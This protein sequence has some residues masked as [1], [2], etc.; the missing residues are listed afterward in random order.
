MKRLAALIGACAATLVAQPAPKLQ[1]AK[2]ET[3]AVSGSLDATVRAIVAAHD[4]PAWIGYTEPAVPGDRQMCCFNSI[5]GV[6]SFG[7]SLEPSQGNIV[8]PAD[9]NGV[10]R[11]EGPSEFYLFLRV[12]R[13]KV[14]KV[15]TFSPDCPIDGGG[16]PIYW[17]TG[18][19]AAES[20]RFLASLVPGAERS[21]QDRAMSAIA[22]HRDPSAVPALIELAVHGNEKN[23]QQR[24]MFW[25]GHSNDPA[26]MKF[27][28]EILGR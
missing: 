8:F 5:N 2:V 10:V 3:R 20:V 18:A 4:D 15:R 23:I 21:L 22:L 13:R 6:A 1:N 12:E 9:T 14:E 24:A 26:A 7:C 16:L 19:S 28:S 11:L 27:I 17:L 25:L